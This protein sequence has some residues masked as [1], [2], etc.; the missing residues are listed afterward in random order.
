MLIKLLFLSGSSH[1]GS[2][3]WRL[4]SAAAVVAEQSFGDRVEPVSLDLMQFDLP[5][6]ENAS[7]HDRPEEAVRLKAAFDSVS[8]VFMSSDEYTGTYSAI[9]RNAIGWLRRCDPK[10]RTPL[11]GMQVALCG[12]FGRGTGGLRGQ[13]A[14][15]QFLRELGAVVIPQHLEMVTVE[16]PFDREGRLLPKVQKQLLDGCLGKLCAKVIAAAAA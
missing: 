10:L 2:A 15:Q 1:I 8:G 14:L 13:P 11:D 4:A 3:N 7:E 5:N 9:L 12:T 16:N 6:L